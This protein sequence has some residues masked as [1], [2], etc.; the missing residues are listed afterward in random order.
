MKHAA[1]TLASLLILSILAYA[2]YTAF[3]PMTGDLP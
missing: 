1:I 2:I 3:Q